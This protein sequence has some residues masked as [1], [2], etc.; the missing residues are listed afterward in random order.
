[1]E[2]R[3]RKRVVY[4]PK[5]RARRSVPLTTTRSR[6]K[7][8]QTRP[9]QRPCFH[10]KAQKPGSLMDVRFYR[11]VQ[12]DLERLVKL[13]EGLYYNDLKVPKWLGP[14]KECRMLKL[15]D[16]LK[17]YNDI[18]RDLS[19]LVDEITTDRSTPYK[20]R[21]PAPPVNSDDSKAIR[22]LAQTFNIDIRDI[23]D[24]L[25]NNNCSPRIEIQ[26]I[27]RKLEKPL[28]KDR[29]TL[30]KWPSKPRKKDGVHSNFAKV[31][32]FT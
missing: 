27:S 16:D 12:D 24:G 2:L 21:L 3:K 28:L 18:S 22:K 4:K 11:D 26:S 5:P 23:S 20:E 19:F 9:L 13:Q 17:I 14:S 30:R 7:V 32:L 25:Q 15:P 6:A 29:D 1:M 31:P 10:N 8:C